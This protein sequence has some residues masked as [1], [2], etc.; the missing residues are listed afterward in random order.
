MNNPDCPSCKNY[1]IAA[2]QLPLQGCRKDR[3]L[4]ARVLAQIYISFAPSPVLL[5]HSSEYM[6][7]E[8]C[9]KYEPRSKKQRIRTGVLS[10]ASMVDYLERWGK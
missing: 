10:D 1:V 6:L 8:E 9:D 3:F 5:L 4:R 2:G 7:P